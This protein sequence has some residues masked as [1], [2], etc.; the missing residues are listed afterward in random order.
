MKVCE[1][2]PQVMFLYKIYGDFD[3][4]KYLSFGTHRQTIPKT[5]N[6]GD[7]GIRKN[8]FL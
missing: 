1:L 7:R 8:K 6:R 4:L 2:F 5:R 3:K